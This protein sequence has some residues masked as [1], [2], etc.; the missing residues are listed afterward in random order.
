MVPPVWAIVPPLARYQVVVPLI[1]M[2]VPP[3]TLPQA[4]VPPT[5]VSVKLTLGGGTAR[6]RGTRD[7]MFLGSKFEST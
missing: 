6:A 7:E 1:W 3:S 2:V 4:V 5:I